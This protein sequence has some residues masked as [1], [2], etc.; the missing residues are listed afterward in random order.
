MTIITRR[1]VDPRGVWMR[2]NL[3]TKPFDGG[4]FAGVPMNALRIATIVANTKVEG[5]S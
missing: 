1:N 5:R 2:Q 4:R 3:R